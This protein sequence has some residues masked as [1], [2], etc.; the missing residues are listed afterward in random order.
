LPAKRSTRIPIRSRKGE[1]EPV[2]QFLV[3]LAE[4]DPPVWRRIQVPGSYTFWDL[5]VAIQDSMGWL[6]YHLHEFRVWNPAKRKIEDVGIPDDEGIGQPHRAGW[7]VPVLPVVQD[8]DLPML[9]SYDFG[10]NWRHVV[11]FETYAMA[12]PATRY[13][14]CVSGARKCPP[15]DCGGVGGFENFLEAIRNKRHPEHKSY[16]EWVGG[17][18]NPEEFDPTEVH[19]DDPAERLEMAMES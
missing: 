17:S 14:R 16:L 13:P 1:I 11:M 3:I 19:F 2:L 9:Y 12:E 5:H 6:D 15:E 18:Y 4:T 8:S 10:D 7:D